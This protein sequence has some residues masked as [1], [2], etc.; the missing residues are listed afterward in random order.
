MR[1]RGG[2]GSVCMAAA[3]LLPWAVCAQTNLNWDGVWKGYWNNRYFAMLEVRGGKVV[4]YYAT[5]I[6]LPVA[7]S[8]VDGD[9]LIVDLPRRHLRITLTRTGADTANAVGLNYFA[10]RVQVGGLSSAS[11]SGAGSTFATFVRQ[12]NAQ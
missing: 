2:L 1:I 6:H 5:A 12:Q 11:G 7:D 4:D 8:R 9:N 3:T 10:G